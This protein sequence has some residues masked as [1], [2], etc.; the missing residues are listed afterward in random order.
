VQ[1]TVVRSRAGKAGLAAV[2]LAY[3]VIGLILLALFLAILK[4]NDGNFTYIMDDR[5]P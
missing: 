3:I 5:V 2:T 1:P 4:L